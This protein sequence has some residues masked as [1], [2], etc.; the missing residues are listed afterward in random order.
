MDELRYPDLHHARAAEGWL[1]LGDTLEAARELQELSEQGRAHPD[2]LEI[3][4][5]LH[6]VRA[7]WESALGVARILTRQFPERATGWIHQSFCLH[8]LKRT[9]E[10]MQL[11]LPVV[12]RFPDESTIPYNL[13]C[14]ACQIGDLASAKAWLAKAARKRGRQSVRE[15]GM[16]DPDLVPLREYLQGW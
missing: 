5:R 14:Y 7:D 11:L 2:V 15:M 9:P 1:E 8:E 12:E 16:D 3:C 13:A 6:A 10:A 4:W